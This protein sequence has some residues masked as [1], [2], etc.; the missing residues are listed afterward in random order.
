MTTLDLMNLL[1]E[2]RRWV[3][4]QNYFRD[5]VEQDYG[6]DEELEEANAKVDE[7]EEQLYN[8]VK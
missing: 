7:L 1:T 6:Y 3:L 8:L 5:K 2:Y 4:R